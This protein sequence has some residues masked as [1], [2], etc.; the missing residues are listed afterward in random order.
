MVGPTIKPLNNTLEAFFFFSDFL[1]FP[2]NFGNFFLDS[3]MK[4]K[5]YVDGGISVR[6][7]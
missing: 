6:N 2:L 7:I 1:K 3:Q 5:N 4:R